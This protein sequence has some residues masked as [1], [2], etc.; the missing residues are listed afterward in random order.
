MEELRWK[1]TK[2]GSNPRQTKTRN[3]TVQN[4]GIPPKL[5]ATDVTIIT[6]AMENR[7]QMPKQY[8]N[9]QKVMKWK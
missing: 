6:P 3:P 9:S 7:I 2:W 4:G 8:T 5:F 1:K